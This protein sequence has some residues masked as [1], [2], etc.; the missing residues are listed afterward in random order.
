M[1][2]FILKGSSQLFRFAMLN[3]C[4]LDQLIARHE[5]TIAM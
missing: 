5:K 1:V 4:T 2:H 3:K